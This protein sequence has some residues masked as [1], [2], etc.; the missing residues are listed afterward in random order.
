MMQ[1][2][3]GREPRFPGSQSKTLSIVSH[4][5]KK[6]KEKDS[7]SYQEKHSTLLYENHFYAVPHS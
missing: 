4:R 5:E 3:L 2:I 1:Q 6:R 7:F